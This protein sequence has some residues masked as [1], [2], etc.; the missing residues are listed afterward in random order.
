MPQFPPYSLMFFQP[1]LRLEFGLVY[2]FEYSLLGWILK[3]AKQ[4]NIT[5][6]Y[7]V[8]DH[9]FDIALNYEVDVLSTEISRSEDSSF[10]K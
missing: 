10:K 9:S 7:L 3:S 8:V 2:L 1:E 6:L 4:F 5:D